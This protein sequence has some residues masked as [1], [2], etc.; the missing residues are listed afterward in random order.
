MT[1][2]IAGRDGLRWAGAHEWRL[3]FVVKVQKR[4]RRYRRSGQT[5]RPSETVA[6]TGS[7]SFRPYGTNRAFCRKLIKAF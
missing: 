7:P 3:R 2:R 1:E 5:I 4:L 6:A